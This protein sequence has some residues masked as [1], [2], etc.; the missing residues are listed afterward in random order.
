MIKSERSRTDVGAMLRRVGIIPVVRA[1]SA[2]SAV[3]VA[4]TLFEAGLPIAEITM[5]VPDALEAIATVTRRLGGRMLVGAG[6]VTDADTVRSATGAGAEF[7]ASPCLI[8]Q[9][10][11]AANAA[12]VI[13]LAGAL[14]PTEIFVAANAGADLVKVFPVQSVGGAAYIRAVRA[15]FPEIPLVPTGGVSLET[16]GEL[17]RAGAAAVGVGGEMISRDALER[18][19]YASIGSLAARHVQAVATARKE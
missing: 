17:L 3:R 16:I 7:V 5:T 2:H 14:T 12:G 18:G 6:T 4:E 10:I 19:D 13:V 1:P 8:P 9:V 15:P 11:S